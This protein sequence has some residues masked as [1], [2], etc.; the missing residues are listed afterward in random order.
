LRGIPAP[1]ATGDIEQ[2]LE[3]LGA[4]MDYRVGEVSGIETSRADAIALTALL[5]LD[6]QFV[7]AAYR[8]LSQ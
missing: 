4:S 5:G 8:A 2:A 3:T 6:R 1:P 7:D